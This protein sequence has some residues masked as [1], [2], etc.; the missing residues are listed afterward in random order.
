MKK[1]N[2]TDSFIKEFGEGLSG[3]VV[4]PE[5]IEPPIDFTLTN[6]AKTK[7]K[8][9]HFI[10]T[11]DAAKY[12]KQ[13]NVFKADFTK[14]LQLSK[15]P[16]NYLNPENEI[17]SLREKLLRYELIDFETFL[18]IQKIHLFQNYR[19]YLVNQRR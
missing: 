4:T 11:K 19:M 17:Y 7:K 12:L 13:W 6:T 15:D 14:F 1:N 8:S 18:Q 2:Y 3:S 9:Q 5:P 10:G 16:I